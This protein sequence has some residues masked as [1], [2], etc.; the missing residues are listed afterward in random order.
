MPFDAP[1][2]MGPFAV[3]QEGRLTPRG[4][5]AAPVFV[6]RWRDRIVRAR[7][8]QR[9]PVIGTLLLSVTL[10]RVPSTACGPQAAMRPGSFALLHMLPQALP[11]EWRVLLLPDHRVRLEAEAR[12]ELP[13]TAVGLVAELTRFLLALGPYLDVFDEA[14]IAAPPV[15]PAAGTANTWPG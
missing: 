6:L 8:D 10:G 4:P 1:F 7:L 14:G 3:D 15:E 9:T 2:E 13:I 5:N 12:I 11:T